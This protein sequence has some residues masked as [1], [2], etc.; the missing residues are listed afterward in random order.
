MQLSDGSDHGECPVELRYATL[1]NGI[2]DKMIEMVDWQLP[3]AAV[4]L[5]DALAV[6]LIGMLLVY[7][8]VLRPAV[9]RFSHR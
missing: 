8:L 3:D 5:K 1:S 4:L 2:I 9:P 7:I 6:K